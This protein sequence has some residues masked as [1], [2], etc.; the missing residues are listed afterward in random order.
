MKKI[1]AV[2]ILACFYSILSLC[3]LSAQTTKEDKVAKKEMEKR[4]EQIK[5]SLSFIQAK[6]ALESQAFAL[7]STYITFKNGRPIYSESN[8]NFISVKDGKGVVQIAFPRGG[9]GL[10]GLGGVT[11]D[12]LVSNVKYTTDKNGN[13]TMEY[14]V[15][16][17]GISAR[18]VVLLFANS[19][20]AQALVDPNF[21]SDDLNVYGKL[22]PI[23][24]SKIFQG[25]T[26]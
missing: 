10:N 6:I 16:G 11:V 2:I 3:P 19:N 8:T 15:N 20:K 17:T 22:V 23:Q 14:T 12:G 18:I 5:D 25:R 24:N 9:L 21:T 13:I 26:L 7:E 4:I 1:F